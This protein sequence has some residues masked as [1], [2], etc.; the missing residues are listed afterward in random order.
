MH[1]AYRLPAC[2][3][4]GEGFAI[5]T[6]DLVP[7]D[8]EGFMEELWEFQSTF[9]D[10]FARSARLVMVSFTYMRSEADRVL[11]PLPRVLIFVLP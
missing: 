2:R 7:S 4:G 11:T 9:H 5:P 6:F 1:Q 3:S 10:C 8:V